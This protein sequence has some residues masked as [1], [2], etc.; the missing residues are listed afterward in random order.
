MA[1]REKIEKLEELIKDNIEGELVDQR[2]TLL[3]PPGENYG[4]VMYK[5]DFNVS[6]YKNISC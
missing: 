6:R 1:N 5:V 3:L 4:S 2:V